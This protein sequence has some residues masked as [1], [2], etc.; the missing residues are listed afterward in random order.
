MYSPNDEWFDTSNWNFDSLH[1]PV[2]CSVYSAADNQNQQTHNV[3]LIICSWIECGI[4]LY[5]LQS[6]LVT[7]DTYFRILLLS[8]PKEKL[9][10]RMEKSG[11]LGRGTDQVYD[12]LIVKNF[13]TSSVQ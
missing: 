8:W 5:Q 12:L 1:L 4:Y 3:V 11:I 7:W 6:I 13:V 2:G 9:N 10:F